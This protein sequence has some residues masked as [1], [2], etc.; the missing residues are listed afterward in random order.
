MERNA[1][2]VKLTARSSKAIAAPG[3]SPTQDL[4]VAITAAPTPNV[5]NTNHAFRPSIAKFNATFGPRSPNRPND[6]SK[7]GK[8]SVFRKERPEVSAKLA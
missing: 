1:I 7:F 6:I 3:Y 2:K 4:L 5:K 8:S